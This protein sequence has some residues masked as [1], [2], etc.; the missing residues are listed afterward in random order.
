VQTFI[1]TSGGNVDLTFASATFTGSG[2]SLNLAGISN[3]GTDNKVKFTAALPANGLIN[4]LM[5]RVIL[6][7]DFAKYD[8][9]NG[10]V[11]LAPG[12]YNNGNDLNAALG[13]DAMNLTSGSSITANRTV[14]ALRLNG[15]GVVAAGTAGSI[16]IL[17]I[18]SGAILNTGGDN[19]IGAAGVDMGV[20]FAANAGFLQ[21]G[22]GTTLSLRAALLGTGGWAKAQTGTLDILTPAFATGTVSL[23][24]G[25]T[26][27]AAGGVNTMFQLQTTFLNN[28][29]TLDLN[30]GAQYIGQLNDPGVLANTGGTITTSSGP[31]LFVTNTVTAATVNTEL[32]NAVSFAK[33][34]TST[35]TIGTPWT[36]TGSTTIMGGILAL[37]DDATLIGTS[38]ININGGQLQLN[39]NGSLLIANYS[40]LGSTIPINLR[41][42]TIRFDGLVSDASSEAMGALASLQG[43]NTVTVNTGGVG[44]GGVIASADVNFASLARSAGTTINFTGTNLGQQGNNA[45]ITF[46]A[47]PS[48]ILGGVLGSWAIHNSTD[49]AAYNTGLGVG[50]VGQGGF[51]GYSGTFGTGLITEISAVAATTTNLTANTSTGMLRIGGAFT[52]DITFASGSL[53]LNLD[54]GGLLRSNNANATTIGTTAVRG[55]LTSGTNELVLFNNQGTTTINSVITGASKLI[56]SGGGILSLTAGNTYT[57]GTS[58]VQGTVTLNGGVG[59]VVIPAGGLTIGGATVTMV[60]NAGQINSSNVVTIRRSS[61][62]TLVGNNTLDSLVFEN[63]G[64]TT[65]PTV[66]P[67]GILTLTNATPVSITTSNAQTLPVISGGTLALGAGAKTFSVEAPNIGGQIYT[68]I[69]PALSI[70]S[71]ITGTGPITKTGTGLLQLSGQSTFSGLTVSGGGIVVGANSTPAS[72]VLTSGPLGIGSVAMGSGSRL[73]ANTTAS[74]GNDISFAG[75]PTFDATDNTARTLT[76]FGNLTGPG[77][78]GT[79]TISIANPGLTVALLGTLPAASSYTRTGLGTLIFNATNYS[80]NFNATALGNPNAISLI[81]DGTGLGLGTGLVQTISMGSVTFDSGIVPTIT[82]NRGGSL[83]FP[84]PVNKILAPS[85]ISNLGLGLTVNTNAGY[86]LQASNAIA[87]TGTPTFNVNN[88]QASNITQGLYLT[89]DLTGTGFNKIGTGTIVINNGT[90]ANNTFTGNLNITQGTLSVST[91]GQLGNAANLVVLNPS[92]GTAAFRAT[93]DITTSR[94]IQLANTANIRSIEV[95]NGKTLQLNSAFDLNSGAGATASLNKQDLGTLLINASNTGWS[96]AVN[97]TQGAILINNSALTNPLGTGTINAGPA[98]VVGSTLQ[99]AGGVTVTNPLNLQ[100]ANNLLFGGINSQGQLD[101]VSGTNAYNGAIS[102][103]FDAT[104]GARAGSV[105]NIGGLITSTGTRRLI[106]NAEGNINPT[107][108]QTGAMFGFDKFGAGTLN[109]TTAL[110]GGTITTG[111]IKV[112]GGILKL[113]G[114]G[115][116]NSSGAPNVVYQGAT[117]QLD[118]SITNTNNRLTARAVTLQGGTFD[119]IS[120]NS[121]ETAGAFVNDQGANTINIGGSGTAALTFAGLTSS[122]GGTLNVTGT[123]GTATNFLKFTTNPALT[124]VTTGILNRV[125]VDGNEFASYSASLGVVAFTGYSVATNILSA[126]ATQTFKATTSTLNSLTGNQTLNA[127]N[128]NN[129]AAVGGLGGNPPATLTLT[130]GS[131]FATGAGGAFLNSP[132]VAFAGAEGIIHVQSGQ[133]LTVNSGMSGT[134]GL[135]KDL[136]GTL[137]INAQQFVLG[138]HFVNGGTLKLTTSGITNPLLFNQGLVVNGGGTFDLNGQNQFVAGLSSATA[139]GG[140]GVDGGSVIN[141]GA[142]QSTFV[143]NGNT[144][145]AGVIS[146]NIYLNKTNTGALN[147]QNAQTY[148]GPTLITGG[149]L[150]LNDNGA[151]PNTNQPIDINFGGLSLANG[152][153]YDVG[154]RVS[155]T[156]PITLRGGVLTLAGRQQFASSETLGNIILADGHNA[157]TTNAG[158]TNVNSLDVTAGVLSRTGVTATVRFN[159][160]GQLGSSARLTFSGG[161]GLS[162]NILGPWAIVDREYASYDATYGIGALNGAGFAGYS[163][164]GINGNPTGTDNVRLAVAGTTTLL[165]NTTVNTLTF[166]QQ[167]TAT[168]LDLGGNILTTQGI[169]FG[170]VTDSIN[171]AITNGSLT[172]PAGGGDLYLTHANFS[173]TNRTVSIDA[174]ITDNG[175]P[176]RVIKTSG[177]TGVSVMTWNGTNTYTG[178]TVLNMGTL[179]LGASSTL[180]TGG[181]TVNQATLTQTAGAV[182]PSQA[183]TLG[184]GSVVTFAGNNS[185]TGLTINNLGGASPTLTPTGVLTLTGGTTVTTLNAGAVATIGTGTLDLNG[186]GG[187]AMNIGATII[188]GVDMAPWQAGLVINSVI[189]NGGIVKTGAGL[190][191]LGG[192]ST[193]AGGINVTAGGLIIGASSTPAG[194]GDTVVTGPLGAGAVT[195]AANTTLVSTAANTVSNNFTF[196]GDTVFNGIQNLTLNGDTTLPSI[197]NASVTAP[198]M[199]VTIG[200]VIGSLGSDVVNKSGL[201]TLTLG[202]YNGTINIAG[203]LIF[204]ADGNGLGTLE[205]IALGGNV[206][207]TADTA[208][209]VNRSGAAPN[210][211]N[212]TLQKVDLTNNGSILAV[213]NQSGYGLEFTGTTILTGASHFSVGVATASNLVQ[214]LTLSGVVSDTGGFDLVKSGLGTLA[215]TNGANTFGGVGKTISVLNG[216][217]SASSDGALGNAANSITLEVDGTTGVGFRATGASWNTNRTFNLNA[218]NNAIEVVAGTTFTLNAPFALSAATNTL[219]KND[220]GIFAINANNTG[221]TGAVNVAAGAI[222]ASHSNAL[223]SGAVT[224]TIS[225]PG[226]AIQLSGGVTIANAF[227]SAGANQSGINSNGVIESVSGTNTWSGLITQNSGNAGT[228]G[229]TGGSSLNITGNIAAVSSINFFASSGSTVNLQSAYG[230]GGAGGATL[231]KFGAGT[232]NVTS[233]QSAVTSAINVNA[234]TMTISGAGVAFGGTGAVAINGTGTLSINDTGTAQANRLGGRPM[235]LSGGT[236]SYLGNTVSSTET[237]GV[238]TATRPGGTI[239]ADSNGGAS[240]ITFGSLAANVVNADASLNFVSAGAALGTTGANSNRI[241]F[242]TV[243]TLTNSVIQRATVNGTEFATHGANGIAAFT[244]YTGGVNINTATTLTSTMLLNAAPTALTANRAVNAIKFAGATPLTLSSTGAAFVAGG[245]TPAQLALTAGAIISDGGVTHTLSVPVLNN[246]AVQNFYTVTSGTTLNITSAIVGTAGWVKNGG[247]TLTISAPASPIGHCHHQ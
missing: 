54:Q 170:Q 77:L 113:S 186:A 124:P 154:N 239:L 7:S 48:T 112:E 164:T 217:L 244:A 185:M 32:T 123:Y 180:G 218:L 74:I 90:P 230:N 2:G 71:I 177:D 179:I 131:I 171:F 103:A 132:I 70:T 5:P 219:T 21:V 198:Q 58:V 157:F 155:D 153:L 245:T 138:N 28:G 108:G 25:T 220:N 163:G 106:F 3:L 43:A 231:N 102:H 137:N 167:A 83:P 206:A 12:D 116:T 215:L 189:Q 152:N 110:F 13:T 166:G 188:N 15:S 145:F 22:S 53:I 79:P 57:L 165:S 228:F 156:A 212:K 202:N 173:G 17:T 46:T 69:S 194:L 196:L 105:L 91:N 207:L 181:L 195:M 221:W 133:S 87:F 85:S 95:S 92:V 1:T 172:G 41:D 183:L 65:A 204:L 45:R 98:V 16:T 240:T 100:S 184:G 119:F 118:N 111:G 38:A 192:Q 238:L 4:G 80:G 213:N 78:G 72:G 120:N 210:A 62:L 81:H 126:T 141:S 63:N 37:Q 162:Y 47:A 9:P 122:A 144:N 24:N 19:T 26:K 139:G 147:L 127:L 51:T 125:T 140:T 42:G 151:L 227:F 55:V 97:I 61:I 178:G 223:G 33:L 117:L 233:S 68:N 158:G 8:G 225:G 148:T 236:F 169:L 135:S 134:A 241:I 114:A 86:G 237:L 52:N 107:G 243:P 6:G 128:I 209:T 64:G 49:Y 73:V 94:V 34:N 222:L 82:V 76:L 23:L 30:G 89:G 159:A 31:A 99:L 201:G 205:N 121:T 229:A 224:A 182:I 40:R 160:T 191:Q 67:G 187:Y 199:T 75:T 35:L 232:L 59:S 101:N 20:N 129:T 56:K 109:I 197:W 50:A 161:T 115:T 44:T 175:G 36:H 168:T 142:G 104:I 29:A 226:S 39:N 146:G 242:T 84:A 174:A 214:G 14:N 88:T 93:E 96:G 150:T 247:G 136:A 190:L 203:G 246:A 149:T 18:N 11:A 60:A 176:T 27:L 143:V 10:V 216:L 208:I 234:G 235:T 66:T 193:F 130:S 211:R 200:N